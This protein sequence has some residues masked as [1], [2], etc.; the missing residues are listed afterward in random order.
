MQRIIKYLDILNSVTKV[1]L[2]KDLKDDIGNGRVAPTGLEV[3]VAKTIS[4]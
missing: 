2:L 4:C 1:Y 3:R